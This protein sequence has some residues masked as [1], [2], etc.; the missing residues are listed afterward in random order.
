MEIE[1]RRN[2]DILLYGFGIILALFLLFISD[3]LSA[4]LLEEINSGAKVIDLMFNSDDNIKFFSHLFIPLLLLT[5]GIVIL[6]I[7]IWKLVENILFEEDTKINKLIMGIVTI[8]L[9]IV[10][11]KALI[12]SL[13]LLLVALACFCISIFIF[14]ILGALFN[15]SSDTQ[16]AN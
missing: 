15:S 10:L 12:N 13:S 7:S 2:F 3:M 5:I 6:L 1:G 14:G 9:V 4:P 16:K 11:I 8:I